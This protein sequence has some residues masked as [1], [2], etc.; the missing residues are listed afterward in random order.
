MRTAHYVS[1]AVLVGGVGLLGAESPRWPALARYEAMAIPADNPMSQ[2]KVDLGRQL[3]HDVRMS[4]DNSH[5]CVSCHRP[6]HGL[7]DGVQRPAGAYGKTVGRACPSLWNVGYQQAFFW[8]GSGQ[9]L[10]AAIKGVWQ[11]NLAPGGEGRASVADV[12]QRLNAIAGYHRQFERAFGAEATPDTVA[13]ALACFLRTLVADRSAWVRFQAGEE[14]ALSAEARRGYAVFSGKGQ[15]TNCHNG[16][17]LTDLQFHNVGIGSQATRPDPG[18]FSISKNER[19]RGA[20]KTPTLLNAA[21]SAPY[22]HDSSVATLEAAVDLMASGG[23]ENPGLDRA[24]L[25]PRGLTALEKAQLLAF[26]RE[27]NVDADVAPPHLPD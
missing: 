13:K 8:E 4:G 15:C 14:K 6:E 16:V 11:Y 5:A 26:L 3:F 20:F 9:S 22:F 27:L 7:S 17:L 10:E 19:D 25:A 21:R 23:I 2:D 12:C 24:S 18:R 1:M